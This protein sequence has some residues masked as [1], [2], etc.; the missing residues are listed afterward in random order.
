MITKTAPRAHVETHVR[1]LPAYTG[2][3]LTYTRRRF[4]I[5]TRGSHTQTQTHAQTHTDTHRKH[6]HA[7]HTRTHAQKTHNTQDPNRIKTMISAQSHFFQ[8]SVAGRPA[9]AV[10][11]GRTMWPEN[12]F[13][14]TDEVI[15]SRLFILRVEPSSEGKDIAHIP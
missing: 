5:H 4:K 10:R 7:G 3:F 13:G 9:R 2:T 15:H 11:H 12:A 14:A 1:V 6:A 8:K